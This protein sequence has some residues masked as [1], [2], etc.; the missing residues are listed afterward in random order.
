MEKQAVSGRSAVVVPVGFEPGEARIRT[1]V[2]ETVV[3]KALSIDITQANVI[4][5]GGRGVKGKEGFDML[6]ELADI[7]GGEVACTRMVVEQRIMPPEAQ[8]GQTGRMVRPE[9]YI[10]CGISGAIQHR[11]GMMDSRYVIAINK[12]PGAPIFSVA[13]WGIVGDVNEVVPEMIR[14]LKG[15]SLQ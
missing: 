8:V 3:E 14:Q 7:L 2:V 15:G 11:A 4:V 6:R 9:I 1:R 12:D 13:D 5:A 10:A